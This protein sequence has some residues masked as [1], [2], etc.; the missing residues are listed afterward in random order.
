MEW[1]VHGDRVAAWQNNMEVENVELLFDFLAKQA[2]EQG[3]SSQSERK[4]IFHCES[5]SICV[6]CFNSGLKQHQD[7][8]A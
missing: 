8:Q 6:Y 3:L 1:V 5:L 2:K 7:H 4:I